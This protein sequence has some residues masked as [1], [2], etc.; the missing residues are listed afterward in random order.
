[1]KILLACIAGMSTGLL[2]ERMNESLIKKGRN[3]ISVQAVSM[4][5]LDK[6]FVQQ[7]DVVLIGPQARFKAPA[8]QKMCAEFNIHSGVI[9]MD[10]YGN[11]DGE[12]AIA[13][14]FQLSNDGE[15]H[16]P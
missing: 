3:D 9:P 1:M 12:R 15:N 11:L 13:F 7:Y 10:I 14:A 2:V 5:K 6:D 4:D 8:I 16:E